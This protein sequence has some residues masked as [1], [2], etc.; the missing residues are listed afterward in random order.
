MKLTAWGHTYEVSVNAKKYA[1]N[2]NLAVTMDYFDDEMQGWLPYA[3]LTVNIGKVAE[4]CGYVDTNN[5]PWAC[6]FIIDNGLGCFTGKWGHSGYCDY[7]LFEFNMDA[8][9][10]VA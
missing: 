1:D 8:I 7:P 9:K 4:N 3:H 10:G 5:C 2:G 6:K